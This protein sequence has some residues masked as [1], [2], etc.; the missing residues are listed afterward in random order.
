MKISMMFGKLRTNKW[1][2]YAV[3]VGAVALATLLKMAAQPDIIPANIPILFF[4]AIVP[5]AYFFEI[6]PAIFACLLSALAYDFFF[7]SLDHRFQWRINEVPILA[8]FLFVGVVISL[9]ES[10]LRKKRDEAQKAEAELGKY[11]DKL[12]D[13]VKMRTAAL[14]ESEQKL[15]LHA[16]NSPLAIV[17]WDANFIVTRWAGAAEK[18]LGWSASETIGKPISDLNLIYAADM[19]IVEATMG[20]LTDGVTRTYTSSNRNITK[21]G[22]IIWCIWYNSVL[23]DQSGKMLSVMSEVEDIT[24]NKRIDKAKDEFIG[25]VSHELRNPLSIMI[26]SVQT[27]LSPGLSQEEIKFLL[28]NAAEGGRSMDQIISNL[29]EL[30]RYQVNRLKLANEKVDM[31]GLTYKV[32]EQVKVFHPLHPYKFDADETMPAVMGDPIR[33]ERILYN[34]I[35]NAAKYSPSGSEINIKIECSK[36]AVTVSVHDQGIG[37]PKDRIGELFEPF[38]RLV[39]HSEST[40]GLGLGLVVVKRLVEAHGGNISVQSEQGKGST[41]TFTLPIKE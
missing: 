35:E 7:I 6:G 4:L 9:L 22:R 2:G 5:I 18:M 40:K 13:L 31:K 34:L 28:Q 33:V 15:R 21:D 23:Y 36:D 11:R 14:F 37:I 30:S 39:D 20:I 32:I 19:P 3:A 25:L 29:L 27:A 38:Q 12:E 8:I 1:V 16:E 17:E 26:G 10:N 41:F 24:E